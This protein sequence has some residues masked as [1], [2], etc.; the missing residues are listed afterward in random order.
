MKKKQTKDFPNS[1]RDSNQYR[2]QNSK[3]SN[4][5][6]LREFNNNAVLPIFLCKTFKYILL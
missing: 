1:V 3:L 4:L 6:F 5:S 2:K